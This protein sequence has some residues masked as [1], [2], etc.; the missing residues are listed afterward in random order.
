MEGG[1]GGRRFGRSVGNVSRQNFMDFEC[2]FYEEKKNPV[3]AARESRSG[4]S[5]ND[6]GNLGKVQIM[7][8]RR[9]KTKKKSQ[10]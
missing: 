3:G 2:Y 1:D 6:V 10:I 7:E 8:F 4:P 9:S 5:E